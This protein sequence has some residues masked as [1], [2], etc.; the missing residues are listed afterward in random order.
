MRYKL[1]AIKIRFFDLIEEL[2]CLD[3]PYLDVTRL[4]VYQ[5]FN[6]D[7]KERVFFFYGNGR[8]ATLI[9]LTNY[10]GNNWLTCFDNS[11]VGYYVSITL[12]RTISINNRKR[13]YSK[14]A[15][16]R[17]LGKNS[18]FYAIKRDSN[19]ICSDQVQDIWLEEKDI[20]PEIKELLTK[21]SN[22]GYDYKRN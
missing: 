15:A 7:N 1:K 19:L 18:V 9:D 2:L 11:G 12:G 10:S 22:D 3:L 17:E 8:K 21:F 4:P 20:N 5:K 13:L 14:R 16:K 6:K